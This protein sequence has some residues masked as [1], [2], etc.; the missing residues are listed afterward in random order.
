MLFNRRGAESTEKEKDLTASHLVLL[1][2][3]NPS[4]QLSTLNSQLSFTLVLRSIISLI[5][6]VTNPKQ[7]SKIAAE[8]AA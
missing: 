4:S 7:A 2:P 6:N 5:T 1:Y 3:S 8:K